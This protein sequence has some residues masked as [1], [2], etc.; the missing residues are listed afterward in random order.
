RSPRNLLLS[1]R[2]CAKNC[3]QI[4]RS[5]MPNL[6]FQTQ[7][8]GEHNGVHYIRQK[9]LSE[10]VESFSFSAAVYYMIT[11]KVPSPAEEKV[12]NALLVASIDH[13]ISPASGF[14]PRVAASTGNTIMHSMAAGL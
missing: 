2:Y 13:G 11:N 12:F 10:L 3:N 8:S 14:V 5:N 4:S 1:S 6:Q 7:V 9:P